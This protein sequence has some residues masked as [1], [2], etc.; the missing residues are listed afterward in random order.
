[1]KT[2]ELTIYKL[3]MYITD[4]NV[5]LILYLNTQIRICQFT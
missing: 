4:K 2:V 1:M 3:T 5:K